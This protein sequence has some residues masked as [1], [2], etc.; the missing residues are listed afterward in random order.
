M[1]SIHFHVLVS[2]LFGACLV[3]LCAAALSLEGSRAFQVFYGCFILT[4]HSNPT[5]S[6]ESCAHTYIRRCHCFNLPNGASLK[7]Y[8]LSLLNMLLSGEKVET[9]IV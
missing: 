8:P 7:H 4:V 1:N 9:V 3:V 5:H 6:L 2:L